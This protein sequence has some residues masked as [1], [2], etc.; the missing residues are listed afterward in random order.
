MSKAVIA[1]GGLAG[2][3]CA[4]RLVDAGFEVELIEA[5]PRFGG[6]AT[7]WVDPNREREIESGIHSYFGIYRRLSAL[8]RE[9]GVTPDRML[10]WEDTVA[11]LRPG[12]RYHLFGINPVRA[13]PQVVGGLLGNNAYLSPWDKLGV[14]RAV[15]RGLRRRASYAYETVQGLA[16]ESDVSHAAYERVLRP[17]MR[18]LF[19]MD[20]EDLA[21]YAPLT[22][23][24]HIL[25]SPASIRAGTFRGGMGKLMIAPLVHWLEN[26]GATLRASAPLRALRHTE[27]T[28]NRLTGFELAGGEV[29][30]GDVYVSALP[31]EAFQALV[32]PSWTGMDYFAKLQQIE[33][34]PA[35]SVQ[36]WF[37]TGLLDRDL[38]LFVPDSPIAILQDQSFE[39]FPREGS[40]ISCQVVDR[41]TDDYS[42]PQMIDLVHEQLRRFF[43]LK[44][45]ARLEEAVVV[46]HRAFAMRPGIRSRRP[47]QASPIPGFYLAGDYTRQDWFT[48][49]EGAVRSGER[50]AACIIT[51]SGTPQA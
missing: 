3:A 48:T 47:E 41:A 8:L 15:T 25:S 22:L 16:Y 50:A 32:P 34:V 33:T 37:D 19:F 12:P 35:V 9:V 5:A 27:G 30:S 20:P 23:A 11:F 36:L 43:P 24:L 31:V 40:R 26:H 6:R 46:R 51:A 29:V 42:D 39:T 49:M 2:L 14:G 17:L 44:T 21:A 13:L 18:S 1:G 45:A 38:Y 28:P 10:K 7:S 4:K